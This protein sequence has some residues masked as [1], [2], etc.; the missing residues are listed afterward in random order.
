MGPQA[1]LG[2]QAHVFD[3]FVGAWDCHYVH[4]AEDGSA[5]EDYD[6]RVTFGWIIDGWAVSGRVVGRWERRHVDP[7]VRPEHRRVDRDTARP[8]GQRRPQRQGR[9]RGGR[10]VLHG[11]RQDGSLRRWSFNDIEPDSF[12]WRGERSPNRGAT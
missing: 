7:L 10:I 5:I 9:R 8:P 6:G 12:V 3:R 4:L 11:E 1:S 2:E